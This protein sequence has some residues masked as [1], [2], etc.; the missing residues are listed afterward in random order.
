MAIIGKPNAVAHIRNWKFGGFV[1]WAVVQRCIHLFLI[2]FRNR[3]L[4]LLSWFWSWCSRPA[5][6]AS[7]SANHASTS[8][9]L[10]GLTSCRM[11][12]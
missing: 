11:K 6:P 1:A 8:R 4:I 12:H 7:P 2:G 10:A 9:S 5:I 3:G